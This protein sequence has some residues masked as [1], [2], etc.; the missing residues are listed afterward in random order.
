M[1]AVVE[2]QMCSGGA[3][4]FLVACQALALW[5]LYLYPRRPIFTCRLV[6]GLRELLRLLQRCTA[7]ANCMTCG[8]L[9]LFQ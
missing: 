9:P 8:G 5:P 7:A 1:A 4:P 6:R 2:T 3:L